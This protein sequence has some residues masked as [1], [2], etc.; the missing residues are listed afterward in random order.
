VGNS[1]VRIDPETH[2]G[3]DDFVREHPGGYIYHLAGWKRLLESCFRHMQ[4]TVLA[5]MDGGEI[6]AALSLYE[7][8]SWLLGNRFVSI[9][10]AT[11]CDP[12]VSETGNASALLGAADSLRRSRKASFLEIRTFKS[13][14]LFPESSAGITTYK[15][16]EIPLSDKPDRVEKTFRV[17]IRQRIRKTSKGTLRLRIGESREDIRSLYFLNMK[18]RKRLGL[19]PQPLAFFEALWKFLAP[20]GYVELLLAMLEDKPI[21]AVLLYKFRDRV[22]AEFTATDW[23]Q[24]HLHPVHFLYWEAIRRACE[25]GFRI[26]DLGRTDP[27]N[28]SLISFKN[29]WGTRI[30]DLPILYYG[31]KDY[32]KK[33]I[34]QSHLV[35]RIFKTVPSPAAELMGKFCY[36]HMG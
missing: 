17:N 25:E 7:V 20:D 35:H 33:G 22:S 5:V 11:V 19:P 6:R 29:S 32:R 30:A 21:A 31:E 26:F 18:T 12:L 10:F 34:M 23:T 16:H 9:P 1:I 15:C 36:A 14:P 28:E 8:R 4:G 3:W 27:G 24:I 13:T 2:P